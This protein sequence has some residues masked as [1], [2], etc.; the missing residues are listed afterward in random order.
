MAD[1]VRLKTTVGP[2]LVN[3][4]NVSLVMPTTELGKDATRICFPGCESDYIDIIEPFEDVA[5]K[6]N[7][8][9]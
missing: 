3:A 8:M 7:G 2:V 4:D 1:F 6:L 5:A 9:F